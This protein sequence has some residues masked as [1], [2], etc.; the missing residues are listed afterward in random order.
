M[1]QVGCIYQYNSVGRQVL[2]LWGGLAG[3]RSSVPTTGKD[4]A[5]ADFWV[6]YDIV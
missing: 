2:R 3:Q 5:L 6:R 1:L 4:A